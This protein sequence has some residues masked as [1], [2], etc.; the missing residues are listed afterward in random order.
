MKGSCLCQSIAYEI[1]SIDMPVGHC[2][3][4]T[5][6]KA[7]AAPFATTAGVMREHFRWLKGE[8]KLSSFESSPGKLRHFCS[9]CGSHLL[10]ERVN[11]PHVILRIATLDDD[12]GVA[13]QRHIWKS[14]DVPWL[15][16]DNLPSYPEWPEQ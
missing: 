6:Q 8:E 9:I 11:Q 4:R 3:C 5:C 1:D 12:P 15:D 2:H 14:H 7:H 10:A 16:Y 13:P